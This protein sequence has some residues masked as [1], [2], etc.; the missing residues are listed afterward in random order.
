VQLLGVAD[1]KMLR[2][3]AQTLAAM[4]VDQALVVHGSGLDEVA[5]HAET[6]AIRL[7]GGEMEELEITPEDAGLERAPLNAVAGGD[8]AENAARLKALLAG[9]AG[10][11]EEDIV[12][13]NTAAL[14]L[15]AGKASNLREGA[16]LAREG[17]ESGRAADALQR[18][19]EASRG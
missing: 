1:P 17:L 10:R 14:L 15:T 19:V 18:F 9:S 7:S 12:I 8:V 5:L 2:R 11:A 4:G 16:A 3:I 13:L 6:R